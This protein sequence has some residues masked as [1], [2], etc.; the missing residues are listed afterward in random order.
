MIGVMRG[1]IE[2]APGIMTVEYR[3]NGSISRFISKDD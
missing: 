3:G 2:A 1:A